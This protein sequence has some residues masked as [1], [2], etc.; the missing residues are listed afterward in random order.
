MG[1]PLSN[2]LTQPPIHHY[3]GYLDSFLLALGFGITSYFIFKKSETHSPLYLAILLVA[4][5]CALSLSVARHFSCFVYSLSFTFFVYLFTLVACICLYRLS[6]WHPLATYPGPLLCKLS[7]L[8]L[9]YVSQQGRLHIYVWRLHQKYGDI[10]RIGPNELSIRS[11]GSIL[12]LLG[13]RELP[14]G[15]WFDGRYPEDAPARSLISLRNSHEHSMRR[16]PWNQAFSVSAL[17]DYEPLIDARTSKLVD[18]LSRQESPVNLTQWI[19]YFAYDMMSDFIFGGGTEMLRDGDVGGLWPMLE[20]AQKTGLL[21]SH[22]PWLGQLLFKTPLL[23]G[24][25]RKMIACSMQ[26]AR[27][28]KARRPTHKDLF[29]YLYNEGGTI[30]NAPTEAE[31]FADS[32]SAGADTSASAIVNLFYLLLTNPATYSRLRAEIDGRED[33]ALE[34][35]EQARMPYL[36]AVIN[37]TLRI[38]PPVPS[39][40]PRATTA[41]TGGRMLGTRY[42]PPNTAVN[43]HIFSVHRDPRNFS[44]PD[45]FV[46]ERW[47]S[48][49]ERKHLGP[50]FFKDGSF[51]HNIAA[52]HPFSVGPSSCVGKNFAY[53]E[54][55]ML[56]TKVLF[57]FDLRLA[58]GFD[59]RKYKHGIKDFFT[60]ALEALPVVF[61]RRKTY[62]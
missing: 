24:S 57:N 12:P 23:A 7:K 47:L 26:F 60:M 54:M 21:F 41:E 37:E 52:F 50:K 17:K 36:N 15:P 56:V 9:G 40:S 14:K 30:E 5:P 20:S 1:L 8:W 51:V 59:S 25:R 53:L 48:E 49:E 58:E 3:H 33:R 62:L 13:P 10:V 46:P 55:R 34:F 31:A 27:S 35:S 19:F 39:G 43:I 4:V 11:A 22:V 61:T 16:R 45:N 32:I 18:A 28:R 38:L 42:I 6:P 29:Y 44:F 2:S